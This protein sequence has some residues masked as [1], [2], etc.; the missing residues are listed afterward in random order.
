MVV[1]DHCGMKAPSLPATLGERNARLQN[2]RDLLRKDHFGIDA[3]IQSLLDAFAPWYR[4][5]ETQD[6]PRTIGLWG[7][8]GTGKSSLVRALIAATGLEDRTFWF[9]AGECHTPRWLDE[10]SDRLSHCLPNDPVVIVVDEFQHARTVRNGIELTEPQAMRRFWELLDPGTVQIK[11]DYW[12]I[13]DLRDLAARLQ[14]ALAAGVCIEH[15]RVT[16]A[17][18]TFQQVMDLDEA[19]DQALPE[20]YERDVLSAHPHPAP[21]SVELHE[22]VASFNGDGLLAWLHDLIA[23]ISRPQVLR[24]K[25]ALVILLGNLDEL[26]T[27]EKVPLAELDPDVLLE[28]H[29]DIGAAGVQHALLRM[30]RLEQIGRLGHAHIIFPPIGKH[31]VQ[32]M[33]QHSA[34]A[35]CQR[36]SL[37]ND[38]RITVDASLIK[39]LQA[40]SAIAVLGARPVEQAIHNTIPLLLSQALD[41][42][43]HDTRSP[44]HLSLSADGPVAHYSEGSKVYIHALPGFSGLYAE[45]PHVREW[46]AVHEVGHL[47]CGVLLGK[48]QPLQICARSRD[49]ECAGFVAWAAPTDRP[50]RKKDIVPQLAGLL[51]GHVAERIRYGADGVST[52]STSDIHKATALAMAMLKDEGMGNDRLRHTTYPGEATSAFHRS[53]HAVEEQARAWLTAAELLAEE[54]LK[55]NTELFDR[56]LQHVMAAGSLGKAELEALFCEKGSINSLLPDDPRELFDVPVDLTTKNAT[57]Q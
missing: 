5:A 41:A 27:T 32:R 36:L 50:F 53:Q 52:G 46:I 8:T 39:H 48:R 56:C 18:E 19:T 25:H 12:H 38:R 6:R 23:S 1:Q 54:T 44:I 57:Q 20:R 10:L 9:D 2:L 49:H 51:A 43:K 13:K 7:M 3:Q 16:E 28:R 55:A 40:S 26:Y 24:T 22:L 17:R 45:A 30:F 37:A 42:A 15:G 47:L 31:T 34:S 29:R 33:V 35:L 11:P 14:R 4:F 21:N